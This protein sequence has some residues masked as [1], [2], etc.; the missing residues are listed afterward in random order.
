[1]EIVESKLFWNPKNN[2][3]GFNVNKQIRSSVSKISNSLDHSF[4]HVLKIKTEA[5]IKTTYYETSSLN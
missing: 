1:M 2:T 5:H 3:S 4:L